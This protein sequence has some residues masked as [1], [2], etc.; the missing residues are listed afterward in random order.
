MRSTVWA[1]LDRVSESKGCVL[2]TL[3]IRSVQIWGLS[4]RK[5]LNSF[6]EGM[7]V[8][9][10]I[11]PQRSTYHERL[12]SKSMVMRLLDRKTGKH[13]SLYCHGILH[14]ASEHEFWSQRTWVQNFH[15]LLYERAWASSSSILGLDFFLFMKWE[16]QQEQ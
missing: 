5:I 6:T 4:S 8:T 12:S 11:H 14:T 9:N 16:E 10:N 7:I 13:N 3:G 1:F 2:E 15:Q